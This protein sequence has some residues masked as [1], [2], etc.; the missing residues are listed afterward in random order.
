MR[1]YVY[2]TW[3]DYMADPKARLSEAAGKP[4]EAKPSPLEPTGV[5][6]ARSVLDYGSVVSMHEAYLRE[7]Y[8][9]GA[10]GITQTAQTRVENGAPQGDVAEWAVEAR[11]QLKATIRDRG[12]AILKKVFESRNLAKYGNEL[13]PSYQQLYN[14][15]AK[16]GLTPE[17][18]NSKIIQGSGK[19][20]LKVNRWAGRLKIAGRIL[21][22][23]DIALAGV[24]VALAPEGERVKT[25]LKEVARIAGALAVGAVGAKG[26]AAAG[27]AIGALFGGAGA[28]PGAII[29]GIIG[30]IGGAFL[31]GW[32]GESLVEKI[33]EMFPPSD[34]VFEG[35]YTEEER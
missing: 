2:E 1:F 13:G 26:G 25:A 32:L 10:K 6:G 18:I 5:S 24:R 35:D 29:G 31:G 3:D 11:N 20:N 8:E 34:C 14:E 12:N 28:I 33:Y 7:I 21:L 30:G 15:L 23:L 16:K 22:A 4:G 27:A 17:E 9:Q 19:A